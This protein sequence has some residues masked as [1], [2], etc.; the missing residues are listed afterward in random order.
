MRSP[1]SAASWQGLRLI[2]TANRTLFPSED[3]AHAM[4]DDTQKSFDTNV[5]GTLKTIYAFLPLV[6]QGKQKKVIAISSTM[7]T[8]GE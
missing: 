8:L 5:I 3:D 7:G 4:I 6:K 2:A 1:A